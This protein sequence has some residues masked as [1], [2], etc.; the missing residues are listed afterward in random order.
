MTK[1][2][3]TLFNNLKV[4]GE[5]FSWDDVLYCQND[6]KESDTIRNRNAAAF[7]LLVKRDAIKLATLEQKVAWFTKYDAKTAR[8]V[9]H[10][11]YAVAKG[12]WKVVEE[13]AST[14]SARTGT[15]HPSN[16]NRKTT[17]YRFATGYT[18]ILETR[19]A[20]A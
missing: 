9:R 1:T 20:K 3:Q 16:P 10:L 11:N 12:R 8:I 5:V 2:E 15:N 6:A 4:K 7:N 13:L 17:L 14:L 18:V 19:A